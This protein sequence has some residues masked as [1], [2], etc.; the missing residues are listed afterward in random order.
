MNEETKSPL[1]FR[2]GGILIH[3]EWVYDE[4]A[5]V[6]SYVQED[7]TDFEWIHK[8]DKQVEFAPDVTLNDVFLFFEK[9]PEICDIA[10]PNCY[11]KEYVAHWKNLDKSCLGK[12]IVYDKNGVEYLE[13]YWAP[14]LFTFEGR[15]EISGLSMPFFH[16][17]GFALKEEDVDKGEDGF[18]VYKPGDRINWGLDFSRIV[19]II[20]L[21]IKLNTE[22]VVHSEWTQ[23]TPDQTKLIDCHRNFTFSEAITGIMWEI[24]FYGIEDDK[25]S[26]RDEI[27]EMKN[28]LDKELKK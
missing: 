6:G 26:K 24:S 10:F 9:E 7:I 12:E 18:F 13:L 1:E 16:G 20:N 23:K 11:I 28:E 2:K 22:F 5:R 17:I 25:I 21:P 4:V 8:R 19:D 15:T 27:V 14:D 3:N